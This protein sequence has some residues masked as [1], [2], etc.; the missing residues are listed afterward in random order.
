MGRAWKGLAASVPGGGHLRRGIEC[1]DASAF[2]D[3]DH[4]T[5]VVLDGRGSS[6]VSGEGAR[7]GVRILTEQISIL[8]PLLSRALDTAGRRRR[9]GVREL[10]EILFRALLL[11]KRRCARRAN[12]PEEDY[13]FTAALVIVGQC[14]TLCLQ[15]GDGA[16]VLRANGTPRVVFAPEKGEFC[17][18]TTFVREGGCFRV[19]LYE[20]DQVDGAAVMS[21]GPIHRMIRLDIL[22]PGPAFD[23]FFDGLSND[24]VTREDLFAYLARSVWYVQ[25]DVRDGDDRSLAL[26]AVKNK[27]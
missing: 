26:M 12:R 27:E 4:P 16:I 2:I 7:E 18:T 1:Q 6:A 23:Y 13:D 22:T 9:R 11:A 17:N 21:D 3:G 14:R 5:L 24:E 8:H 25:T 15:V 19:A 20:T 10:S